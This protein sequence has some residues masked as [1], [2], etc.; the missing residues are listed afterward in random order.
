MEVRKACKNWKLTS[1]RVR[2]CS[3][4]S[5]GEKTPLHV[6][7]SQRWFQSR[8]IEITNKKITLQFPKV[9]IPKPPT[10]KSMKSKSTT[11]IC[12][13][14]NTLVWTSMHRLLQ[15]QAKYVIQIQYQ[16]LNWKEKK[17]LSNDRFPESALY[18]EYQK[19]GSNWIIWWKHR[20]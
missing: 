6:N 11:G 16:N 14:L 20:Q 8:I 5:S 19:Q 17:S 7:L 9:V 2:N 3:S 15:D 10:K 4:I 18:P 12:V 13:I 1:L